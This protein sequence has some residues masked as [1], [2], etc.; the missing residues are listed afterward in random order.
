MRHEVEMRQYPILT[1]G[2]ALSAM[3]YAGMICMA[4]GVMS[5]TVLIVAAL[6]G[7]MVGFTLAATLSAYGEAPED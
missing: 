4:F 7:G 5:Q 1:G 3:F 6:F 2:C